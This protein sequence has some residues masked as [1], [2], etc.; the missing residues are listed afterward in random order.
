MKKKPELPNLLTSR[1]LKK[2]LLAM[3][4]T[5]ILS[6][7]TV[8]QLSASVYSQNIRFTFNVQ[9][10]TVKEI[11]DEI[12][13]QSQF[14]FFYNDNFKDLNKKV[15][16]SAQNSLVE[17][18]LEKLLKTSGV[19][20]K[21]L[22]NN[23]IVITTKD[24]IT[25]QQLKIT[26]KVTDA[27]TG[28]SLPGVNIVIEGTTVGTTTDTN[29]NYSIEV[30]DVNSIL[31]YTFIGYATQKIAANGQKAIDVSLATDV[32]AL[33]EV[34]VVGYGTM[35][36]GD[37]TSAI[38]SVKEKDFTVGA[39]RDASELIKGK[40]AGLSI[41]NGSG[42]PS[43]T[44]NINLRGVNSLKG[45]SSPLVLINGIPGSLND[46][47]PAEVESIDVL[48]DASAAAIY[49]TRGASGV[50]L[51]T[52]KKVG[53]NIPTTLSYSSYVGI[54]EF[55]KKAKFLDAG[56][57][58]QKLAEGY[59]MPYPD[60]GY[61]TDWLAEIT[62][63]DPAT[64]N[65]DLSLK[66][67]NMQ[68]NYVISLNYLKQN[69]MFKKS[70]NQDIKASLDINHAMF[71]DKLKLNFNVITGS[72]NFG[73]LGDGT[74]F[75]RTIYRQALIRNPTDR[76]KD[77]NGDWQSRTGFQYYNPVA[78]IEETDGKIERGWTRLTGNITVNPVNGWE[79]NLMLAANQFNEFRGYS[80]TSKYVN[81]LKGVNGFASNAN[82]KKVNNYLELTSKYSKVINKHNIMVLGGY[83]YQYNVN[84]GSWAN[85]YD[86][87]TDNFSYN[88][89]GSGLALQNGKAGMSSS[90]DDNT[91][92]GFFGRLSYGFDNKYNILAS[93]RREGSSKFGEN[94][95]FG[96]FPSLSLGWTLSNESFMKDI[97]FIDN[98][99]LRGGYGVTGRIPDDS[100]RSLTIFEYQGQFLNG[101][102]WVTGLQPQYNPN[103]DLRWEKSKEYNV[104]MDFSVLKSRVSGSIDVYK[105]K[106]TDMLWDFQV[107]KPPYYADL[108]LANV[109][110]MEN[111]GIEISVNTTPLQKRNFEWNSSITFSNNK[112][113]VISISNDFYKNA[114]NF[115]IPSTAGLSD[116][117]S[118]PTH[119]IEPGHPVGEFWGI[120]SVDIDTAGVWIIQA[121]DGTLKTAGDNENLTD[122][123]R[124]YLGNGIP[125]FRAGWVNTFRY[126]R[127]EI[128]VIL[129]GAFG[130]KILNE[131]RLFYE[132][133]TVKYNRL[134]S[135]YDNVYGKRTLNFRQYF[136]SYYLENGNYVK[137]DNLTLRYNLNVNKLKF[138]K[139]ARVYV[140]CSN[141]ATFTKYKGLDP[142]IDRSDPLSQGNDERDKYPSI[143]TYTLGIQIT[144]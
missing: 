28:E 137:I 85:N 113:K 53:R 124:Q 15:D 6:F 104:G 36:K 81:T 122:P 3:K 121:P 69:G 23:L 76:V 40:I 73:A 7:I 66:G 144:F 33:D 136:T 31:V 17:D 84:S 26:G 11:L 63:T 68:S 22:D 119:R 114:Q 42:D 103:P 52:T 56:Q 47:S 14:R 25:A 55:A 30:T 107:P 35:K 41:S 80:E 101:G 102:N 129:N 110:E 93:I 74:S 86:F 131:Q 115:I 48:K 132:N 20:F 77:D 39:M 16:L 62:R 32:K 95:K 105:K 117:V 78:M 108:I 118:L 109:G 18:V 111:K 79:T 13:K 128:N 130:F 71:K 123:N 142:E 45:N 120:K 21:V 34:V 64:Q 82:D 19:T 49:G 97:T 5:T 125:K 141:L 140:S 38:A 50:I 10:K 98:L 112:N 59:A 116:P 67:G 89:L 135:S 1:G 133:P 96:T 60:Q 29:G 58:R 91:L 106:T 139:E 61:S 99:K 2:F 46:V 27:Q 88:N 94:Y 70:N 44:A 87:P 8:L 54:S 100:Y 37:I 134:E 90:K 57:Y 72:Q 51:I 12:E 143:R 75:D 138:F 92:V 9:D 43:T 127:L 65:H 83:S 126:K 4:L 24:M